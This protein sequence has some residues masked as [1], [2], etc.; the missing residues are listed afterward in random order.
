[1][2][3]LKSK[4]KPIFQALA[5]ATLLLIVFINGCVNQ[6][7]NE[8]QKLKI[9]MNRW[10]GY[11]VALYAQEKGLFKQRGL[12][13]E[14]V[15][16]DVAQDTV[17]ATLQGHLDGAFITLWEL[18]QADPSNDTPAYLMVVDVSAGSDGIVTQ[19]AIKSVKEL[20]GKRVG[21]KLGTV[22]HLI[23]LEAL[24]INDMQ[25]T[26]VEIVDISNEIAEQQL[27]EGKIDGAVIW[28]PSL[29][30]LKE[31]I[32]G[33]IIFT[34]K[35]TDSL[36]IDGFA[37]RSS[38]VEN[39][40]EAFT[41]FILAWFD[42]MNLVETQ[43]E[44]VFE[45]VANQLEQTPES[46]ASDYAGLTKGDI[47]LNQRMF[48]PNGRLQEATKEITQLLQEDPRHSRTIREDIDINAKPINDAIAQWKP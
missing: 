16:F 7:Q 40:Q 28:E 4:F 13:V 31:E 3:Y 48:K 11:D 14:F 32:K 25:P 5:I 21:A 26:D 44:E 30:Q 10:P 1:M 46:F 19:S 38:F 22:S 35:D 37:S 42:L 6:P 45:V 18:M 23:L 33:N 29:S 27:K 8:L 20:K 39:N 41:Q 15:V 12:D 2:N 43:P 24:K 47:A 9:G 36:I 34:T 17:R